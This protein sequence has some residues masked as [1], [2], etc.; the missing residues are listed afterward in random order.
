MKS[1][2]KRINAF[3]YL[4]E[5]IEGYEASSGANFIN[6]RR[7]PN[8]LAIKNIL[9]TLLEILFPGVSGSRDITS[10]N[11]VFVI[12]DLLST[13]RSELRDQIAMAF[14]HQCNEKECGHTLCDDKADTAADTLLG[15]LP[16][17]RRSSRRMWQQ[18]MRGIPQQP[19]KRRWSSAT[20][21]CGPL[22]STGYHMNSTSS[23]YPSYPG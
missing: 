9:D 13:V 3:G 16:A 11:L 21:G 14:K 2:E 1:I 23:G 10:D 5:L 8:L 20:P 19:Q 12:G 4:D 17:I 15:R 7:L 6:E 22:P 18:P